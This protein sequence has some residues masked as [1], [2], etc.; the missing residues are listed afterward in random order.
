MSI[1]LLPV[2]LWNQNVA[3]PGC[4]D[5]TVTYGV[6]FVKTATIPV[7][8]FLFL[9]GPEKAAGIAYHNLVSKLLTRYDFY[10]IVGPMKHF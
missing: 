6:L 1:V 7:A 4:L 8:V 2:V 5:D 9:S 10:C 3:R